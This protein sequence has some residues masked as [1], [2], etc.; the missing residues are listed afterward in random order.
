MPKSKNKKRFTWNALHDKD[1]D[2]EV[3][4]TSN[5]ME[6]NNMLTDEGEQAGDASLDLMLRTE[7]IQKS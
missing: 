2:D 3:S 1:E 7:R 6:D 5:N 4:L